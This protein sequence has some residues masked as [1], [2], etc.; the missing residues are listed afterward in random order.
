ME[1]GDKVRRSFSLEVWLP[2]L[3]VATLAL[4]LP[5]TWRQKAGVLYVLEQRSTT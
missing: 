4:A 3:V 2:V 5:Y 1:S